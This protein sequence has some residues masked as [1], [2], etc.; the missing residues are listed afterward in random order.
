MYV[1]V[2]KTELALWDNEVP[3]NVCDCILEQISMYRKDIPTLARHHHALIYGFQYVYGRNLERCHFAKL[4][5]IPEF[6]IPFY[7]IVRI[8]CY[9]NIY[10]PEAIEI[11]VQACIGHYHNTEQYNEILLWL[12]SRIKDCRYHCFIYKGCILE[13][14]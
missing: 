4:R 14:V 9:A 7:C 8:P 1:V 3:E 10:F 5:E 6:I 2:S 11:N 12:N 13:D